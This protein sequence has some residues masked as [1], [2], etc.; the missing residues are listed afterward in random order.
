MIISL[1]TQ[2]KICCT[3]NYQD[4]SK[5]ETLCLK[6]DSSRMRWNRV[7]LAKSPVVEVRTSPLLKPHKFLENSVEV[8]QPSLLRFYYCKWFAD[9]QVSLVFITQIANLIVGMVDL[10]KGS[11]SFMLNRKRT[12]SM[13]H[14]LLDIV[15]NQLILTSLQQQHINVVVRQIENFRQ[16]NNWWLTEEK[17]LTKIEFYTSL[18]L[19]TL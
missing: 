17:I 12:G 9:S 13:C 7:D 18:Y 11:Q 19:P 4:K 10:V 16:S 8:T 14:W 2:T 6:Q 15:E 3:I 5:L 1:K